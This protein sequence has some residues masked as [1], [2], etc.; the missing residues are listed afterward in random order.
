MT[1]AL[2]AMLLCGEAVSITVIPCKV[3]LRFDE[4]TH[5]HGAIAHLSGRRVLTKAAHDGG[6][7]LCTDESVLVLVE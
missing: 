1:D 3:A 4:E 7:F 6:Q 2:V 5:S